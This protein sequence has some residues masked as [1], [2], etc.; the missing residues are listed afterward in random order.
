MAKYSD[1]AQPGQDGIDVE[2]DSAAQQQQERQR[3]PDTGQFVATPEAVDWEQR[4]KELEKFN[5]RQAQTL[6][7]Y[8]STIDDFITG[9]TSVEPEP[10][11]EAPSP[12]TVEQLY[13]DPDAAITKAV[14]NH[15]VVQEARTLI[16]NMG[17]KQ[18]ADEASAF[19][20]KHPDFKDI[21]NTPEFQ[22]WVVEDTTRSN[23]YSRADHYDFDAADALVRLYKAEKGMAQVTNHQNI[24]QAELISSSGEMVQAPPTYSRS[25]YINKLKR[26]KQGDLEAEEWVRAHVANYRRALELDNVRD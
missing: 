16:D 19:V 26:S 20:T 23:L 12:I 1:Y 17:K 7:E 3:D 21:L 10:P 25:E 11:A 2:I 13:E 5:S 6:G 9:P 14:D 8:R 24:Q 4:Y 18:R 22:N 15:P